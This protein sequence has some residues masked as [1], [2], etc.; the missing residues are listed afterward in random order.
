MQRMKC[1]EQTTPCALAVARELN[2]LHRI[3][4]AALPTADDVSVNWDSLATE[5]SVVAL[6]AGAGTVV[7]HHLTTDCSRLQKQGES[8]AKMVWGSHLNVSFRST[9][10]ANKTNS[11]NHHSQAET[12]IVDSYNEN[13]KIK[14]GQKGGRVTGG[15]GNSSRVTDTDRSDSNRSDSD[16]KQYGTAERGFRFSSS[17]VSPNDHHRATA[18]KKC[19]DEIYPVGTSSGFPDQW[20]FSSQQFIDQTVRLPI[21]SL[22]TDSYRYQ[23]TTSIVDIKCP[24]VQ[25]NPNCQCYSLMESS[26]IRQ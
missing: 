5:A 19:R 13:N 25:Q 8:L 18:C 17:D 15:P 12:S 9:L 7:G 20:E 21:G 11:I 4:L 22:H 6:M 14:E 23:P 2:Y 24:T 1:Q 26:Y 16:S 10:S 3:I